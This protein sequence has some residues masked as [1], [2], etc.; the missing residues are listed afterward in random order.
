MKDIKNSKKGAEELR[1]HT[2]DAP[3]NFPWKSLSGE[4]V[5]IATSFAKLSKAAHDKFLSLQLQ[6]NVVQSGFSANTIQAV[7]WVQTINWVRVLQ[8]CE[9]CKNVCKHFYLRKKKTQEYSTGSIHFQ[10]HTFEKL[11]ALPG[12]WI[13]CC[14]PRGIKD[15][16]DWESREFSENVKDA[17][18]CH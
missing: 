17:Q 10:M 1:I 11:R 2:E 4:M 16:N 13:R 14:D 12:V 7:C 15:N 18:N 9:K 6:Q 5:L 8:R 3:E